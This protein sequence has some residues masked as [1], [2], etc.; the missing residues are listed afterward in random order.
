MKMKISRPKV[1]SLFV[2]RRPLEK[3]PLT[4][5]K[6]LLTMLLDKRG[7][8]HNCVGSQKKMRPVY[9]ILF[10]SAVSDGTAAPLAATFLQNKH[11]GHADSPVHCSQADDVI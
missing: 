3:V 1:F 5:D 4:R 11:N 2:F 8:I 6:M 10:C 7:P 9:S